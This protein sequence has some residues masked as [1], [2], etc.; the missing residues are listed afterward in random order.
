MA[1]KREYDMPSKGYPLIALGAEKGTEGRDDVDNDIYMRKSAE[2]LNK[3]DKQAMRITAQE[4]TK[5]ISK[6]KTTNRKR[7]STKK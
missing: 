1:P 2:K 4:E 3:R 7:I 5:R 6:P